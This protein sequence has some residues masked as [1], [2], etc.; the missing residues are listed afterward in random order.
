MAV[1]SRT[2]L[3]GKEEKKSQIHDKK[4]KKHRILHKRI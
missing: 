2:N 4:K 1:C 3:N